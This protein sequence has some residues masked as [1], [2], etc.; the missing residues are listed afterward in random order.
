MIGPMG[1]GAL[2]ARPELLEEMDPFLG[3]GEMIRDVTLEGSTWNDVPWK[4]EAGTMM[5]AEA[6]GFGAAIDYLDDLGMGA[7]REHEVELNR[8]G[9]E[10][11]QAVKGLRIYGPTR[12]DRRGSTFSF[13]VFSNGDLI[14]PHDVGQILDQ[15]GVAIRAGHHCAKPLMR[16]FDVPA[17]CRASLYVYNTQGEIDALAESVD[18]A[19][20]FFSGE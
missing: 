6:V 5:T 10:T 13:N 1:V 17:M 14:H 16:R 11:L 18:K 19:R 2:V 8:Y 12:A 15:E 3:G 7:V 4:F 20:V 9:L